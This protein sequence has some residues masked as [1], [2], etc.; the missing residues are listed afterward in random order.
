MEKYPDL[1]YIK[2]G[3]ESRLKQQWITI[4]QTVDYIKWGF[5]SRLKLRAYKHKY[6]NKLYQMGIWE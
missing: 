1:Y 6:K 3:F 5:E 4:K 2:W